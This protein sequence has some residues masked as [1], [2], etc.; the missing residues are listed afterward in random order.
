VH[1][2]QYNVKS[3]AIYD[4]NQKP[5]AS[6]KPDLLLSVQVNQFELAA[7]NVTGHVVIEKKLYEA[8]TKI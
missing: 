3:S 5:Q 1:V 7:N 4:P 2:K 6:D 8:I